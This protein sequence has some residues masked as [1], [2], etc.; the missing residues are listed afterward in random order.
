MQWP[1]GH[2]FAFH[3]LGPGFQPHVAWDLLYLSFLSVKKKNIKK[4]V[5]SSR[6]PGMVY[7][8]ADRKGEDLN[9][10]QHETL[11]SSTLYQEA[12]QSYIIPFLCLYYCFLCIS[13]TF[14]LSCCCYPV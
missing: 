4:E 13:L 5:P 7:S 9:I 12:N 14:N 10:L 8:S 6:F 3:S 2:M 1:R 11:G